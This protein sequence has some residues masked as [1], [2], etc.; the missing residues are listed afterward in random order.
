MAFLSGVNSL[1]PVR[2]VNCVHKL[3]QIT[4]AQ[5]T[6]EQVSIC[7]IKNK[8]DPPPHLQLA[9]LSNS[10]HCA[11]NTTPSDCPYNLYRT[12]GDIGTVLFSL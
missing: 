11:G 6:P 4:K 3:R 12:S 1:S 2:T 10:D 9:D 5:L 7:Y 8:T